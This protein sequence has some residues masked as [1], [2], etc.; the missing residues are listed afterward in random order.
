[1]DT[2]IFSIVPCSRTKLIIRL[3]QK[4]LFILAD[5]TGLNFV[6]PDNVKGEI[7]LPLKDV[8]WDQALDIIVISKRLTK[9]RS[10]NVIIITDERKP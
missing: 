4:V 8:P 3:F 1:M 10:G 6:V 5:F 7:T 2:N 9:K